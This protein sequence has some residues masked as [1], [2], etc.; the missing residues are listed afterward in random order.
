[1]VDIQ[2]QRND[3]DFHRGTFRVRGDVIEVFPCHE[4]EH[5][6]RLELFGDQIELIH[7]VDPLRGRSLY[8]LK[9]IAIYPASHYVTE[10]ENMKRAINDIR[11]ELQER[12]QFFRS[13]DKL[14]EAQRI[15]QR[16]LFDLEMME[17]MGFCKGI[18][19]Y[20]RHLTGRKTAK[21]PPTLLEFFP[22]PF[23]TFI[24]ES[25]VGVPQ[26]MGMYRGDQARKMNLVEYGFRLP[27]A[28]DNRPLRYEE[29]DQLV[30]QV[31]YVSAT[32]SD[33]E[34]TA[35]KGVVVEQLIRPT[36]L[37]DPQ[38]EV[39]DAKVQVDDL[40]EEVRKRIAQGERTLATTLTKRMSEDLTEYI[41]EAGIRVRYLHSDIETIERVEIIRGLRKG[42]FDLLVGINLL[43][44][45]LDLPEVSL[46]AILDADKEGFLR[47]HRSLIQTM[48][49]AA[50]NVNG[51]VI[52]YAETVTRSMKLAI[53]ETDRRRKKQK[54]YNKKN[55]ITPETVKRK[56][57][58]ILESVYER[59]YVKLP[60][61]SEEKDIYGE[62]LTPDEIPELIEDLEKKMRK[63]AKDFRFEEAMEFR[64]RIKEL[65]QM[66]LQF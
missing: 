60:L 55:S 26:L 28:L 23:L 25:H 27:S 66:T 52:L 35:A 61:V 22:R 41:A 4:G 31:I 6:I 43:R 62:G 64:N 58:D 57:N 45:G 20:S 14:L 59:D 2:Y 39:R 9:E 8:D 49:R 56:I 42:D 33:Y 11:D 46:V 38:V 16:T 63:A 19:N 30:N 5:A 36:G 51:T 53:E 3:L 54:A 12:I 24:D 48:G 7:L 50:R 34:L 37:L 1:L 47:S 13:Q 29:F 15:E 21:P 44:E 17:E 10:A 32:P 65:K 40:L 18:E